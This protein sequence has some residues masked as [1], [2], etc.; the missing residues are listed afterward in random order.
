VTIGGGGAGFA[1]TRLQP[2]RS[3]ATTTMA[4][5]HRKRRNGMRFIRLPVIAK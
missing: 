3:A 2:G 5:A 4:A 1:V